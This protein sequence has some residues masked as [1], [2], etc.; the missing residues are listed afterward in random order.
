M[1]H[2]IN[3]IFQAFLHAFQDLSSLTIVKMVLFGF[4]TGVGLYYS[5]KMMSVIMWLKGGVENGDGTLNNKDLQVAT[6]TAFCGFILLTIAF[7]SVE[8]PEAIIYSVFG[9][10]A[11][12]FDLFFFDPFILIFTC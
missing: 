3:H 12:L 4:G 11:A 9:T 7:W 2:R 1:A 5:K 6:F 10:T 8:W